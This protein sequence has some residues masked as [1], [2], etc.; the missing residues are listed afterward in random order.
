MEANRTLSATPLESPL[1][2]EPK[3]Q[4]LTLKPKSSAVFDGIEIAVLWIKGDK[5]RLR[6]AKESP[7]V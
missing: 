4:A 3:C 7:A 5:V 1:R 2:G 6:F